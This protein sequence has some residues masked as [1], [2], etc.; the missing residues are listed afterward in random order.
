VQNITT[1]NQPKDIE[2][3][4]SEAIHKQARGQLKSF[5][6][7]RNFAPLWAASGKIGPEAET[8]IGFL[9]TAELDKLKPKSYKVEKLRELLINANTGDAYAIARAELQLSNSFSR[10]VGDLRRPTKF[11]KSY[12]KA[13]MKPKKL[14]VQAILGA[15][16]LPQS[17]EEYISSMAW[18]SPHYLRLRRLLSEAI[19]KNSSEDTIKRLR[20]N[21]ERAQALPGPWTHHIVVDSASSRLWYYQAGKQFGMMRVIVGKADSPTPML[22]GMLQYA[23]LNP[24]WNVPTDLAQKHIAPKILAGRS[25]SSMGFEALSDWGLTPTKLNPATVDW[26]SVASGALEM[27]LRQL[28]G[29]NNSMGRVKFMF[30]NENGIYLHDTP[31]RALFNQTNRHLSNGCIRLE[32]AQSLG[33]WLL[34]RSIKKLPKEPEQPVPLPAPIPLYLTY[35]SATATKG[36]VEF[37]ADVYGHDNIPPE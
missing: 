14:K 10:Y 35:F 27:R 5:Y 26:A 16:S 29:P 28:P 18:M 7:A 2:A 4:I 15:A 1:L 31:E 11:M 6:Q 3:A 30:P 34:G 21:L 32:D 24:Y 12:L 22:A 19:E 37:L 36:G 33:A 9:T 25:L 23:I 17:F 20:L 13:E 8:L